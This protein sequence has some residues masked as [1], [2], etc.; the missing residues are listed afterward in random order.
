MDVKHLEKIMDKLI[1]LRGDIDKA[2]REDLA[3]DLKMGCEA[4]GSNC[5][6][7]FFNDFLKHYKSVL[8]DQK[9][10]DES[11][12]QV[13]HPW[14]EFLKARLNFIE[15]KR[16]KGCS[17]TEI[18]DALSMDECQVASILTNSGRFFAKKYKDKSEPEKEKIA[19]PDQKEGVVWKSHL[20]HPSDDRNI[21]VV[22]QDSDGDY[23]EPIRAY[24]D[25]DEAEY[26]SLDSI[27][28]FPLSPSHWCELPR[29]KE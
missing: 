6:V 11:E 1:E 10:K 24:Y 29:C 21:L 26:F 16:N 27:M 8:L 12:P 20:V 2:K 3:N 19:Q 18:A 14:G 28:T 5:N 9:Q 7:M 17:F 25:E 22:W 13:K 23:S 4:P 15:W